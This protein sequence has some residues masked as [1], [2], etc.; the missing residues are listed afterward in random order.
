MREKYFNVDLLKEVSS[1]F[2]FNFLRKRDI[3]YKL[4]GFDKKYRFVFGLG[5]FDCMN[6]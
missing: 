1:D 5:L 3:F 4:Q 2:V 6:E